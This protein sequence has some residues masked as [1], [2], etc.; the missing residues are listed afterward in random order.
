MGKR[1]AIIIYEIWGINIVKII[2]W[3][4][5]GNPTN[6]TIQSADSELITNPTTKT[7]TTWNN[8]NNIR[9]LQIS[10]NNQVIKLAEWMYSNSELFLKRKYDK[11]DIIKRIIAKRNLL[12]H[13]IRSKNG[14]KVIKDVNAKRYKERSLKNV[15]STKDS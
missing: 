12:V 8:N 10:G 3:N 13:E 7:L 2:V 15:S 9:T 5:W 14:I 11:I 1:T 4:F 6:G